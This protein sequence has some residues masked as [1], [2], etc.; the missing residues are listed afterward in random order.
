MFKDS[1]T[2]YFLSSCKSSV[3]MRY[4]R[5]GVQELS[6][7]GRSRVFKDSFTGYCLSLVVSQV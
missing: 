5:D 2:G 1:F 4:W 6:L 3:G 7:G